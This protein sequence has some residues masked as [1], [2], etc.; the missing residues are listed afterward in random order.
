MLWVDDQPQNNA[1]LIDQLMGA[2][3]AVDIARSTTEGMTLA[4]RRRYGA[5]ITDMGRDEEGRFRPRAGL[6]LIRQLR[7][8]GD[9]TPVLVFTS[10]RSARDHGL[11]AREL[12]AHDATSS[13]VDLVAFLRANGV[14][15]VTR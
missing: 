5:I 13:G 3:V 6:D 2:G 9:R 7:D 8:A 12:G 4:A 14:M 1:L 15:Q 11:E 10:S